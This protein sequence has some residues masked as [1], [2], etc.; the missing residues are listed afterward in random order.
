MNPLFTHGLKVSCD[1]IDYVIL[2]GL[3]YEEVD[4][5]GTDRHRVRRVDTDEVEVVDEVWRVVGRD[6]TECKEAPEVESSGRMVNV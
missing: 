5:E 1:A 3:W 4:H 2:C 6:R